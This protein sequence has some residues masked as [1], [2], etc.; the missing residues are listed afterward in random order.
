M[1]Q[2]HEVTFRVILLIIAILTKNVFFKCQSSTILSY[3]NIE[4][5]LRSV[6]L[7]GNFNLA[8]A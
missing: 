6:K 4:N 1:M 2:S 7:N 8:Q 5:F 3:I